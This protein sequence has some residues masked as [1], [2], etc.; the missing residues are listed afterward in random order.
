[1]KH[2]LIVIALVMSF[3]TL[4][5]SSNY[6]ESNSN[7]VT[8]SANEYRELHFANDRNAITTTGIVVICN[9]QYNASSPKCTD[10]K[11]TNQWMDIK[12]LNIEGYKYNHHVFTYDI[13][14]NMRILI[15]YLKK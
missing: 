1:M 6:P 7:Q 3:N 10:N 5:K 11:D 9:F 8:I 2:L 15:V 12:F 14:R 13:Y 4:A